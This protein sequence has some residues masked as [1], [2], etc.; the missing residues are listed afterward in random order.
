MSTRRPDDQPTTVIGQQTAEQ[1]AVTTSPPADRNRIWQRKLPAHLG[2]AR[3][4]TAVIGALFL[5]LGGM[6]S[7]LPAQDTGTTPVTTS[8][9]TV[10][11][12][13]NTALPSE[14]RSTPV[15]AAPATTAAPDPGPAPASSA[16]APTPQTTSSDTTAA[17]DTGSPDATPSD[18]TDGRATTPSTTT[19][20][21][22]PAPTPAPSGTAAPGTTQAPEESADP[23]G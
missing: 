8:D 17:P 7:V 15:P 11:Y 3:T 23:T 4:S 10:V 13:P 5:L 22:P 14:A 21:L 1:P 16:P 2:R 20:E 6:D 9:G 12:V 19:S 18:Q